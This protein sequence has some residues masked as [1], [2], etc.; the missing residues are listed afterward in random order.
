LEGPQIRIGSVSKRREWGRP[1]EHKG[2]VEEVMDFLEALNSGSPEMKEERNRPLEVLKN[3]VTDLTQLSQ[4]RNEFPESE[5]KINPFDSFVKKEETKPKESKKEGPQNE[6]S[7]SFMDSFLIELVH[8]IKNSLT[9][10]YHATVLTTGKADDAEMRKRSHDQVKE[11]IKKIDSVLNS[12]IN[13]VN[14]NTPI[15]KTNTLST[16]LEE[17][18]VA[19]EK[20]FRQKNIKIT[21]RYEEDIPETF[22]HPQQV[23]FILHSAVQYIILSAPPDEVIGFLMKSADSPNGIGEEKPSPE[24]NRRYVEVM[25]GFNGAGKLINKSDHV[26]EISEEQGNGMPDLI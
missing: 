19:S 21:K 4:S 8:S 23:R 10:I 22:L 16:I 5:K 15:P 14:I 25:I 13:F 2:I 1:I 26:T 17:I 9:A 20:Q 18:L 12:L 6:Q 3:G 11:E 24:N 7:P